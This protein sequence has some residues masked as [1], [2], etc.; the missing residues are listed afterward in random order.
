[1]FYII[2]LRVLNRKWIVLLSN[3]FMDNILI[4]EWIIFRVVWIGLVFNYD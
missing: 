1:M 4:R 3:I 2:S